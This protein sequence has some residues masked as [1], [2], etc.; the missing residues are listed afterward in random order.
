MRQLF[1]LTVLGVLVSSAAFVGMIFAMRAVGSVQ[2][3]STALAPLHLADCA[4]PCWMGMTPGK[5]TFDDA[6]QQVSAAF[7]H[8]L[9]TITGGRIINLDT[10][11]G[12]VLITG[13]RDGL[14]HRIS[15][16]SFR[17]K[18]VMLGDVVGL[19]GMPTWIVG[20]NPTAIFYGCGTYQVVV[21]SGTVSGG[22]RQHLVI[23]DIQDIGYSCPVAKQ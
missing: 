15:L 23:I 1:V 11:F 7:P 21:S 12:Q 14:I 19:L 18:G 6:L 13:G 17:L 3:P 20:V 16:P 22:W 10:S 9:V 2:P 4:L 8:S 5:T